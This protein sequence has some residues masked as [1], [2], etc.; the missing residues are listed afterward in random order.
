MKH[1]ILLL[2]VFILCILISKL[3]NTES[4]INYNPTISLCI[5]CF[6]RDTPKLEK[7]LDSVKK[8]TVKPDEIIIGHSEMNEHQAKE[9]EK[10]YSDLKIKV[11]STEKKQYAAANRNMA[12]SGNTSDYI[13]FMDADDM[14]LDNKIEILKKIIIEEKPLSIIHN[15]NSRNT[16][17]EISNNIK[18]KIYGDEIYDSLKKSKTIHITTFRVHHGHI[19]IS[20]EVFKNVKQDTSEKWR[21]GQDSK[22]IRDIFKHYGKD[23]KVMIY[24]DI[25][26]TIY[27]PS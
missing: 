8:Q 24:I 20:K 12:A 26:L 18:R 25:P 5:P 1:I 23:K 3:K 19:T 11:I 7:L 6:P 16:K 21:R 27:I 9:L 4:F 14:M 13:S 17:Y 15:Y 10:K 2:L 22:F